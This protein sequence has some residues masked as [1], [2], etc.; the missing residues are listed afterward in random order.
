MLKKMQDI[1][2]DG[3]SFLIGVLA[4][5]LAIALFTNPSVTAQNSDQSQSQNLGD[6]EV[7][8]ITVTNSQGQAVFVAYSDSAGNGGLMV[9]NRTGMPLALVRNVRENNRD[10][11]L[12]YCNGIGL[13]GPE[14]QVNTLLNSNAI[15]F[16]RNQ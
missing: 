4:T 3:K 14:G 9:R 10:T 8:S 16:I 12:I 6:I 1:G 11:G 13:W 7:N 15:Q 5:L 2:L